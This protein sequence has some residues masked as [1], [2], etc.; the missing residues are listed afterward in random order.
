MP[1][2]EESFDAQAGFF[3]SSVEDSKPI[4][5]QRSEPQPNRYHRNEEQGLRYNVIGEQI[6]EF[7][8]T[9]HLVIGVVQN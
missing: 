4:L 1:T 6:I 3:T 5:S 9:I 2:L 7:C 8:L